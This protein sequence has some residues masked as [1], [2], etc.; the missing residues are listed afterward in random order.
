MDDARRYR[1]NAADCLLATK[2]C[3][4]DYRGIILSV[5][6]CWHSLAIQ[7][8]A[9]DLLRSLTDPDDLRN[10]EPAVK[11][12]GGNIRSRQRLSVHSFRLEVIHAMR[13]PN[14]MACEEPPVQGCG[15]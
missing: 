4:P 12:A 11:M 13:T 3:Q 10:T 7:E 5:S 14:R 1:V 8:E 9:I 2:S 15:R 6:A